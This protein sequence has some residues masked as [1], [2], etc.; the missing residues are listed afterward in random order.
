MDEKTNNKELIIGIDDAGRGP[1][2][3]PMVLAGCLIYKEVEEELRR[4]GIKD[5]KLLTAK[6]REEL[7]EIIKEM[8]IDSHFI[9]LSPAEID[10]GMGFGVNLN[11]VEAIAAAGIV[12]K[13]AEKLNEA[14]KKRFNCYN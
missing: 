3:G 10:T 1:V 8:V 14:Q 6:K 7:A 12:N 9:I 5:S 4:A 11:E 13:L 2:I